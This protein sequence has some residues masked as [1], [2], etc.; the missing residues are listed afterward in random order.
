MD[1]TSTRDLRA[2]FTQQ[3]SQRRLVLSRTTHSAGPS[4]AQSNSVDVAYPASWYDIPGSGSVTNLVIPVD[5][6]LPKVF[7]RLR[8]P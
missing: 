3:Y 7:Y 4:L 8:L 6:S 2:V 5:A 1:S